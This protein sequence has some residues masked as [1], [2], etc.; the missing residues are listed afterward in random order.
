MLPLAYSTMSMI[1]PIDLVWYARA[2]SRASKYSLFSM[3]L[4]YF[5]F[6]F[7]S[8]EISVRLLVEDVSAVELETVVDDLDSVD[9]AVA[10]ADSVSLMIYGYSLLQAL[11]VTLLTPLESYLKFFSGC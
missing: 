2:S 10:V 6:A 7:N 5:A 3:M 1:Y 9:A 4:N 8:A 11:S